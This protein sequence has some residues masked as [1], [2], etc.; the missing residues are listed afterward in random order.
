[1]ESSTACS[2]MLTSE[3]DEGSLN[4][5]YSKKMADAVIS[6][7]SYSLDSISRL[8]RK[9]IDL[10]KKKSNEYIS[11]GSG[12]S[13]VTNETFANLDNDGSNGS[14]TTISASLMNRLNRVKE[15]HLW[16]S[17][18]KNSADTNKGTGAKNGNVKGIKVVDDEM[19]LLSRL[20]Q[21]TLNNDSTFP[22]K[23][24]AKLDSDVYSQFSD[25]NIT[26]TNSVINTDMDKNINSLDNTPREPASKNSIH[27]LLDEEHMWISEAMAENDNDLT[28]VIKS[29]NHS[30]A[31]DLGQDKHLHYYQLPFPWRENRYI[32]NGYRF[33]HKNSKLL[34]S[35]FNWYGFHNETANIW[36]HLLGAIYFA[37]IVLF[38][39]PKSF[40]V[41]SPEVPPSAKY[42]VYLFLLAGIKCMLASVFWHT[43]NG[44][45]SIKLRPK[46]CCVDYSGITILIT[47]SILTAEFVSLYDHRSIMTVYMSLSLLFGCF[48]LYLNWSPKFDSPEARPLR[49]KFFIL[50]AALGG[51][52]FFHVAY[53]EGMAYAA[54]LYSPVTSKSIVWYLIGVFF[55]GS[56][57][58]E[59]FRSDFVIDKSIP[60]S[61]QLA[62]DVTIIT[63]HKHVHFRE[64]PTKTN[65]CKDCTSK[66][67]KTLWWVDYI[68]NSHN[69]W[70]V[71]VFLGVMGHYNAILDMFA[72]KWLTNI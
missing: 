31:Y 56:F 40:I 35:V 20:S 5:S 30:I 63:K 43:F 54:W 36:S 4:S 21:D 37:Y 12:G 23:T 14:S 2:S 71:F 19:L 50:L 59:R 28:Y 1:M 52:A 16:R 22:L 46:Y 61:K 17:N 15:K 18:I 13:T 65:H 7:T 3:N 66:S 6:S 34:L 58:P 72:K 10:V 57:I 25:S 39:F 67:F 69:I 33:Y 55:Y 24:I 44:T 41:Q 49:I 29:Y 8:K 68:C 60:N 38:E 9:S 70:H 64:E 62:S 51:L 42:I 45:C 27:E 47:A 48:G 26:L 11:I 53:L 32:I